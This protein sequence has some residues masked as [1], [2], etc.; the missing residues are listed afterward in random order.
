MKRQISVLHLKKDDVKKPCAT[1]L[2]CI[3]FFSLTQN[4]NH[5]FIPISVLITT[6]IKFR[7]RMGNG[8]AAQD[9]KMI[10]FN[11]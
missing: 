3:R 7:N 11:R 8:G 1:V 2:C 6:S 9:K 4:N 10:R 5:P